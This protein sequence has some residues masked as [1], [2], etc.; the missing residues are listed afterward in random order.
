[1]DHCSSYWVSIHGWLQLPSILTVSLCSSML[2]VLL[3]TC[4]CAVFDVLRSLGE[5]F[6]RL[7]M[8][9]LVLIL[10][11]RAFGTIAPLSEHVIKLLEHLARVLMKLRANLFALLISLIRAWVDIISSLGGSRCVL[12]SR[13]F[14]RVLLMLGSRSACLLF[15]VDVV[16]RILHLGLRICIL[17]GAL[18]VV[19]RRVTWV[20]IVIELL[21]D[22]EVTYLV[23]IIWYAFDLRMR[24]TC[25]VWNRFQM[26]DLRGLLR[27]V[28]GTLLWPRLLSRGVSVF[29]SRFSL[30]FEKRTPWTGVREVLK[31]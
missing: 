13:V 9:R 12:R 10:C 7:R 23:E 26:W 1:M 8:D 18:P 24:L 30:R 17:S 20:E 14:A 27:G 6:L 2:W 5:S 15:L 19:P 29:D 31:I 4:L 16:L 28:R 25:E 22:A 3:I 21:R 11:R